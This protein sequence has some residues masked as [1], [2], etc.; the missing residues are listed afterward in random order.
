VVVKHQILLLKVIRSSDCSIR[1]QGIHLIDH[2]SSAFKWLV[3]LLDVAFANSIPLLKIHNILLLL[4][5][6][7]SNQ[8]FSQFCFLCSAGICSSNCSLR[9]IH[10]IDHLSSAFY[11]L[12]RL[13]DVAV[14]VGCY[15][16]TSV[17]EVGEFMFVLMFYIHTLRL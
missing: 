8:S 4:Y 17:Q 14:H 13:L 7:S 5:I 16:H 3:R 1:L 2:L 10:L 11:W 9:G 15:F 12:L 6:L